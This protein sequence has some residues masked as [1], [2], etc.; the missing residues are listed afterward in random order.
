MKYEI[1]FEKSI[2]G[3]GTLSVN[4]TS[5]YKAVLDG[6]EGD[7]IFAH[8]NSVVFI[9]AI[10][11][12]VI[13][14]KLSRDAYPISFCRFSIDGTEIGSLWNPLDSTNAIPLVP[15]K[16]RLE[17]HAK[18]NGNAHSYWFIAG[19]RDTVNVNPNEPQPVRRGRKRKEENEE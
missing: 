2:V 1:D 11:P 6:S 8:A 5:D 19:V 14:G 10:T 9:N 3:Y 4:Q 18:N 7:A 16:H 17:I 15:G 13:Q 12:L